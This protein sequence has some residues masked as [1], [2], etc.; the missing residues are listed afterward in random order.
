MSILKFLGLEEDRQ[1]A[2]TPE[3]E[4]I[5]NIRQELGRLGS[6]K[7]RYIVS[8]AHI[9]GRVAHADES[10][11]SE[12]LAAIDQ[13][14]RSEAQL[15]DKQAKIVLDLTRNR[16]ALEDTVDSLVTAEFSR[17]ANREQKVQLVNCLFS[18]AAAEGNIS[19]VEEEMIRQI[20]NEIRLP[21]RDFVAVRYSY[22]KHLSRGAIAGR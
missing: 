6:G 9:L 16:A 2:S 22:L 20:S 14:V 5:R 17:V 13:I 15:D 1:A 8:F 11:S 4:A 21:E 7:A 18:V 19:K 10:I 12:E 3:T